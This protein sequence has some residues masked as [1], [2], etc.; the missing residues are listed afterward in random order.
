MNQPRWRVRPEGSTWGDFGPDDGL[1][2]LNLLTPERVQAAR[3]EIVSGEVFGLSL[4]LNL[5]GGRVLSAMREEPR[6]HVT[7]KGDQAIFNHPPTPHDGCT[8][9][10]SDD[11]VTLSLQYSTHWDAFGHVGQFFDVD[12][13]GTARPVYYNGF[14]AGIDVVPHDGAPGLGQGAGPL[15][16]SRAAERP[17]VGRAV[18]ADLHAHFGGTDGPVAVDGDM[19]FQALPVLPEKGDI[20]VL[21]TGFSDR[22]IEMG[23]KPDKAELMRFSIGLNGRD[24]VLRDWIAESGI[25]AIASDNFA[26]EAYPAHPPATRPAS[27]LPLHELCL[28]RLGVMLGELWNLGPIARALAANKRHRFFLSAAPLNL[29][30]AVA[31]PLTPVGIL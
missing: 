25:V 19:L 14:R 3:N 27:D 11:A 31:S 20:L 6:L 5:P 22:L 15:A 1:G 24:P 23:G 2:R 4:P 29:P 12:G 10:E 16:I 28:F 26:V 13:D 30:G 7:R 18:L 17:V 21:H 8:D 9:F